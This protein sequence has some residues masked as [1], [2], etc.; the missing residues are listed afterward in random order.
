MP[1]SDEMPTVV[2]QMSGQIFMPSNANA[3]DLHWQ[4]VIREFFNKVSDLRSILSDENGDLVWYVLSWENNYLQPW[5]TDLHVC[6]WCANDMGVQFTGI[7]FEVVQFY[8]TLM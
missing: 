1:R 2:G 8:W 3:N 5:R 7:Q 4:H 6:D